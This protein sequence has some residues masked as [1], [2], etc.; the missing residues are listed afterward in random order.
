M[1]TLFTLLLLACCASTARANEAADAYRQGRFL[2][3]RDLGRSLGDADS[4][5]WACRAGLVIGGYSDDPRQ[6]AHDLHGALEDCDA[7]LA[8]DPDHPFA[9]VSRALA[10]GFEGKRVKKAN[11]AKASREML[12]GA[13]ARHPDDPLV[14]GALGGW[15]AAVSRSGFLARAVLGGSSKVAR[16]NFEQ[17]LALAPENMPIR[18]EFL[19]FLATGNSDER[20]EAL[21]GLVAFEAMTPSDAFDRMLLGKARALTDALKVNDK[22]AIR[23]AREAASAF[24][25]IDDA[26]DE[27]EPYPLA[28]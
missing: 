6:S 22:R 13:L 28:E 7:A 12:E 10:I 4:L 15:H 8:L 14:L 11:L 21:E 18:F 26:K 27:V 19:K 1:R 25:N 16:D 20:K 9:L 24:A 2:V 17:A 3:A 5:A 23:D